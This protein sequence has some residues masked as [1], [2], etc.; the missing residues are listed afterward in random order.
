[1][2]WSA[3]ETRQ[4]LAIYQK[5]EILYNVKHKYY[6]NKPMK[7]AKVHELLDEV[8]SESKYLWSCTLS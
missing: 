4:F 8:H 3:E 6:L 5:Y 1:M 2:K 7:T